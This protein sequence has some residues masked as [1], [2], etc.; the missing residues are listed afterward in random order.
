MRVLSLGD[1]S[2]REMFFRGQ[3]VD[4]V[5]EGPFDAVLLASHLQVLK[6]HQVPQAISKLYEELVDGGRIIVTVPSLEWAC[7]EVI[8]QNDIP[9]SAYISM[10]GPE[11]EAYLCGFT[12]LWL[13]RALEEAGFIILEARTENFRMHLTI[14][15]DRVE[16]KAKQHVVI[17]IKRAVDPEIAL[18]GW[19]K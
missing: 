19:L 9:L 10:Y 1:Q 12:M 5:N 8:T 3:Q 14:G 17:A 18:K 15:Q 2:Q 7:R 6:R 16:E 4:Y 11:G 13:R